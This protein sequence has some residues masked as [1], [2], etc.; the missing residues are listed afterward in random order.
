M[1]SGSECATFMSQLII[2]LLHQAGPLNAFDLYFC[3]T[4]LFLLLS[5][6]SH[7]FIHCFSI[8][9][10]PFLTL[11]I[12]LPPLFFVLFNRSS[13]SPNNFFFFFFTF[14][15]WHNF[16]FVFALYFFSPVCS[17]INSFSHMFYSLLFIIP[18]SPPF[19]I[20]SH[21][22]FSGQCGHHRRGASAPAGSGAV[23]PWGVCKCLLPWFAGAA[24]PRRELHTHPGLSAL[25]H[26]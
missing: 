4:S 24:E 10:W 22:P 11:L 19:A 5:P 12:S 6:V 26:G 3:V 14:F 9:L 25:W 23:S 13:L 17:Y 2:R 1:W 7:P 21:R 15:P 20:L 16:L 18:H 8:I